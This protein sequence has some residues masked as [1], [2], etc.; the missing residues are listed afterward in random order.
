MFEKKIDQKPGKSSSSALVRHRNRSGV[1]DLVR[2]EPLM[3][4]KVE[5]GVIKS[6][7]N[8]R[9]KNRKNAILA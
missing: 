1:V 5:N 6:C 9:W 2:R 3:F 8:F 4:A 7:Q